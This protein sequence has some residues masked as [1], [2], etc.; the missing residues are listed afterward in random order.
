MEKDNETLESIYNTHL[1]V[2]RR[3]RNKPFKVRK[4][5]S[6]FES[7][8][9]YN[10]WVI[11][12]NFFRRFP[13]INK[14]LY[15]KAPYELWKD[16]EY[17]GVDFFIT[18]AATR[19]YTVYKKQLQEQDPDSDESLQ[20]IKDSIITIGKYCEQNKINFDEYILE[21]P[22]VTYTWMKQIRQGQISPYVIFGFKGIDD[23][24]YN[25]PEDERDL[26]MGDFGDRLYNYKE[27][28]N[29]SKYAKQLITIGLN[30]IKNRQ[31]VEKQQL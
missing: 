26:L 11:M 21:K 8:D 27:K 14:E 19:A 3:S 6:G 1:V 23:L 18:P 29:R 28:Y 31:H 24:I 25:T 13:S 10:K 22:G 16:K 4:D 12:E 17:F 2:S 7:S 9:E 30:R 20:Y 5:F 15:F